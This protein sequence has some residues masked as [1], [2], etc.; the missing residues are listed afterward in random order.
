MLYCAAVNEPLR[1]IL[2]CC[3]TIA[4]AS[5]PIEVLLIMQSTRQRILE[6]LKEKKHATVDQLSTELELTPV[7]I[8]HHL[9]ILKGEGLVDTPK[10]LRR[11]GP[12]RP[13]YA[14]GL[15]EAAGDYFPKNYQR[16]AGLMLDEIRERVTQIELEQIVGGIAERMAAQAPTPKQRQDPQEF[17]NATVRYLNDQ[18]YVARWERTPEGEYL[19]HTFNCPYHQVAQ[20]HTE[21]CKIDAN[22]IGQ[23]VGFPAQRTS[24]LA[25]G[26]DSCSYVFRLKIPS[27]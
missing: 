6:I 21:V 26:D 22:F 17:L 3:D 13:Q 7:T 18:G 4:N 1:R 11:P 25:S 15:T 8:R 27:S 2:S 9:E 19:M 10:V 23:L 14:Y 16:L 24:H 5:Q 20:A 12:G